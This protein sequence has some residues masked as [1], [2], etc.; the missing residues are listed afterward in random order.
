MTPEEQKR[1]D[2]AAKKRA[3]R[4]RKREELAS[5][6]PKH[7][8]HYEG[9]PTPEAEDAWKRVQPGKIEPLSEEQLAQYVSSREKAEAV[10][11]ESTARAEY[12]QLRFAKY[13][14]S[15]NLPELLQGVIREIIETR[16]VLVDLIGGLNK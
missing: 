15:T 16:I 6:T 4:Q 11:A 2:A 12:V 5:A 8:T 7:P 13:A 1:A 3:Y 9:S 14:K 10:Q